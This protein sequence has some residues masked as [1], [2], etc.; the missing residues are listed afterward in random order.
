MGFLDGPMNMIS[1]ILG[2]S[3]GA[4]TRQVA[5]L[6]PTT[7][8]LMDEYAA[9]GGRSEQEIAKDGYGLADEAAKQVSAPKEVGGYNPM[10]GDAIR[11]KYQEATQKDLGKLK[12]MSEMQAKQ[13]K[14][15]QMRT[16][17]E[18]LMAKQNVAT[19]NFA[20]AAEARMQAE[21]LRAQVLSSVFQGAGRFAGAYYGSQS[22]A[23][24]PMAG[25]EVA[26][27]GGWNGPQTPPT[28]SMNYGN[29]NPVV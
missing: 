29:Y 15:Q 6:D 26:Y 23:P 14:A 13:D 4:P 20:R 25:A 21:A 28:P 3:G 12:L 16:G 22:G 1:S 18:M 8:R 10:M 9:R 24:K 7:K 11:M 17:W 5:E 2:G 19:Q 27:E